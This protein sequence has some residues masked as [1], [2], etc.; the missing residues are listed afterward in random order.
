MTNI[1]VVATKNVANCDISAFVVQFCLFVYIVVH[2]SKITTNFINFLIKSMIKHLKFLSLTY[3]L[4]QIFY[5]V[6]C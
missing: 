4:Q 1:A 3:H 6:V 2:I 5:S